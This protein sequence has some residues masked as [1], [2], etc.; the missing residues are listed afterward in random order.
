MLGMRMHAA[1]IGITLKIVCLCPIII[2][3]F[4]RVL[5]LMRIRVQVMPLGMFF[6]RHVSKVLELRRWLDTQGPMPEP[7]RREM[8]HH[9][10]QVE[11]DKICVS[12]AINRQSIG[13]TRCIYIYIYVYIHTYIY[14]Y[15]YIYLQATASAADLQ[16]V[17]C[18]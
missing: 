11:H 1:P 17:G 14:I 4:F 6:L 3:H 10:A 12:I 18:G 5:R 15:I 16:K 7:S 8:L 2:I 13:S 9:V